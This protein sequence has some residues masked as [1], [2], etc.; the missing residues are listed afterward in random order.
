MKKKYFL[1]SMIISAA[2]ILTSCVSTKTKVPEIEAKVP[3]KE[4]SDEK[5][6]IA[7]EK[8]P[9]EDEQ[10][11]P[12]KKDEEKPEEKSGH[13]EKE[14]A[15][16]DSGDSKEKAES[17]I[18]GDADEKKCSRYLAGTGK[19]TAEALAAFF[20]SENP[21]INEEYILEFAKIYIEEAGEEGINSDVAFVQMCH[22]TGFLRFGNLVTADMHNYCGL[23]AINEEQRG[24]W[25]ET[26]QEGIRA[27][28]QHLHAYGT[29]ADK[30]LKNECIDPRYRYVNPRGKAPTIEALSGTW[31]ADRSYAEK[32]ERHLSNLDK[33]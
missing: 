27:H 25:Y 22:E 9:S 28:I 2:V 20:L 8:I 11:E 24:L 29:T 21:D 30:K 14:K 5:K 33:F 13:D 19:K 10:K 31:A 4:F 17:E 26:E 3:E 12:E 23:G 32:L 18:A 16:I 6:A 15:A 1:F 7:E